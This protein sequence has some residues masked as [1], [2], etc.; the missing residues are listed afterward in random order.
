[1]YNETLGID[2]WRGISYGTAERF[3]RTTP[4]SYAGHNTTVVNAT[5][6]GVAC[7]QVTIS[8]SS[9]A[10]TDY[11]TYGFGEACTLLDI[12]RPHNTI[13][14]SKLPVM[15]WVYGGGLTQGAS[16]SYPGSGIVAASSKMD[17]S[18]ITVIINYRLALW[19]F[20]GG[21][22]A[23]DNGALN[24]G[25]Y[26]QRDAMQWV[27][28][29][30]EY[31]GGDKDKVTLYGQSSGSMCIAYHYLT[32]NTTLFR[33]AILESGV[34]TSV[35][36]LL[37]ADYQNVYDALVNLTGCSSSSDTFQ[38]IQTVNESV[39]EDA[40]NTIAGT[41]N[42]YSARP[43]AV[44]IDG[45]IIP[46]SPAVLTAQGKIANIPFIV[47]DVQDEG[48]VFVQPQALNT[49]DDYVTWIGLDYCGPQPTFHDESDDALSLI[50]ELYP[51]VES[52]GSPYGTGNTTF[53]GEQF[54]RG[55]ATYGDIHFFAPRRNWLN[56]AV[57]K[58]I[59]SWCYE[60]AQNITAAPEWAGVFHASDVLFVFLDIS[61]T[62]PQFSLAEQ[63]VA[64]W[65]SFANH[66]NPNF[67]KLITGAPIWEQYG[68]SKKSMYMST[69][70]TEMIT[71][72][73]RQE[74][75]DFLLS[76]AD[77]FL[78][79]PTSTTSATSPTQTSSSSAHVLAMHGKT[80]GNSN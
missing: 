17:L 25:L 64:Y 28:N 69:N 52:L 36:V 55:A 20:L 57:S 2:T 61:E 49:T 63:T 71:D 27:Q 35:P 79:S 22:E 16:F 73:F 10:T 40:A 30:I 68:S 48:T 70:V 8:S 32:E 34:S 14:D 58:G 39:L 67:A 80:K 65:L 43:W 41:P 19:G 3:K 45:E 18:V 59:N 47:G 50:E 21:Q 62:S 46:D 38:C 51:D 53:F 12:Y 24:L 23:D 4:P 75:T 26:D 76:V 7:P 11:R 5:Y 29:Y 78:V 77:Q 9:L 72:D 56:I 1:M 44:A 74:Q 37:P 13:S 60:F 54:K 15:I 31:F 33:G 6:P 42:S 66:L